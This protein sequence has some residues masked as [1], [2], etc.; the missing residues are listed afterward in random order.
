[1]RGNKYLL[2]ILVFLLSSYPFSVWSGQ[3]TLEWKLEVSAESASIHLKPDANSPVV[4]AVPRGTILK[5]YAREGD[6]FRVIPG[7]GQEGVVTIGYVASPDV[8]VLEEKVQKTADYWQ[9]QAE[10]FR[11]LGLT[12][13]LNGGFISGA[14]GDINRGAVGMFN[15]GIA[16]L[17]AQGF[18]MFSKT[19]RPFRAQFTLSGDFLLALTS[20]LGIGAGV[21]Y[22][23]LSGKNYQQFGRNDILTNT[24]GS[25]PIIDSIGIKLDLH[26][27]VPLNKLLNAFVEGGPSLYLADYAMGF[28]SP[29]GG[30]FQDTLV[31][32]ARGRALGVWGGAGLDIALNSR[33]GFFL[34]AQGRYAR[35]GNFQG[36]E[37]FERW[38]NY[39]TTT[40][41]SEGSLYILEG[42][43]FPRLAIL[44]DSAVA[45]QSARR[46]AFDLNGISLLAGMRIRF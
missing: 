40:T 41:R 27:E 43:E 4:A 11:G 39:Q 26:Y 34:E 29:A 16:D 15:S 25:E 19:T 18:S 22:T 14:G 3:Q 45:G 44:A 42:G 24:L 17:I 6:W 21:E 31:Q 35:I 37:S 13:K 36:S 32:D 8:N 46:V 33:V 5:S 9:P 20:R 10:K 28:S 2:S 23:R 30:E 38:A 1:M 7:P 12:V